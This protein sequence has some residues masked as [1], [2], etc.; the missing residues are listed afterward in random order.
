MFGC[1]CCACERD[2]I[3]VTGPIGSDAVV[4]PGTHAQIP[5]TKV[6]Q[7]NATEVKDFLLKD[8]SIYTGQ[9]QGA[10][11]HGK[12]KRIWEGGKS[13]EGQWYE[14]RMHGK[15]TFRWPDGRVYH[16][17]YVD[18]KKQGVGSFVWPDGRWFHGE[19]RDG[20]QHGAG[21]AYNL[22]IT[23]DGIWDN[24]KHIT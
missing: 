14:D 1:A 20:M 17:D 8:G 13:Y 9:I 19:W 5:V 7:D 21:Q 3:P 23:I 18:D 24:G 11:R 16:G 6:F 12:G 4:V 22:E 15:G 2:A 10:K